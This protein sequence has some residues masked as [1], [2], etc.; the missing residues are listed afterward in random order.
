MNTAHLQVASL[1]PAGWLHISKL[2]KD[3][4]ITSKIT[5]CFF[6]EKSD[7]TSLTEKQ[8]RRNNER[9]MG[10]LPV[11]LWSHQVLITS[12]LL[13]KKLLWRRAPRAGRTPSWDPFLRPPKHW[14]VAGLFYLGEQ[15]RSVWH[16]ES[17]APMSAVF[18]SMLDYTERG[19]EILEDK[20]RA[21]IMV[22]TFTWQRGCTGESLL[23]T[24]Q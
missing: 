1:H 12:Q 13:E 2:I 20:V 21:S 19:T 7:V 4:I 5:G 18:S 3:Q 24:N 22:T 17:T 9:T 10:P 11:F 6:C 8:R 23:I 14:G 16:R 15:E